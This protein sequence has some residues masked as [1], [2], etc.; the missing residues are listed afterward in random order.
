M[1]ETHIYF[2]SSLASKYEA[3]IGF[4][5]SSVGVSQSSA[6]QSSLR[7]TS[8]SDAMSGVTSGASHAS[9]ESSASLTSLTRSASALDAPAD[10]SMLSVAASAP[11]ESSAVSQSSAPSAIRWRA[12]HLT[13]TGR[14]DDAVHHAMQSHLRLARA[15][16]LPTGNLERRLA[17]EL[18]RLRCEDCRRAAE[19]C[20]FCRN[21]RLR[22]KHST[23]FVC[24]LSIAPD[25]VEGTFQRCA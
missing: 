18:R 3:N 22:Q 20:V 14:A 5:M 24:H 4:K 17:R 8:A 15:D 2:F 10:A 21:E 11:C 1:F 9:N 25:D 23:C 6:S 12:N 19:P 16:Q 7:T 13:G